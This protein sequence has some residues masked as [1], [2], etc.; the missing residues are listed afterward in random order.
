MTDLTD[1]QIA[2]LRASIKPQRGPWRSRPSEFR[3]CVCCRTR[4]LRREFTRSA[5]SL[6]DACYVEHVTP[7]MPEC[8][9]LKG[10]N[11]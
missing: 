2:A 3:Q 1:N 4:K 6:C 7:A 11:K 5:Y 8:S 10:L 9:F